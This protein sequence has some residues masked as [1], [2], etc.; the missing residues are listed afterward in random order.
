MRLRCDS[1]GSIFSACIAL[2]L[3]GG[4][5]AAPPGSVDGMLA[6][7]T[8]GGAD[9]GV[10]VTDSLAHVHVGCTYGDFAGRIAI[11][12]EGNF[13]VAGSY[14]QHAYPVALGPT[15]P[16]QFHGRVLGGTLTY[17]VIVTDTIENKN[18]TLGPAVVRL[19]KEPQMGPCPICHTPGDRARMGALSR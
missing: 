16:A 9:A 12:A 10:I 11:D 17:T 18:V 8:W 3:V 5:D 13:T 1:R 14:L 7:G 4:C 6:L 19:G 15:M 2:A